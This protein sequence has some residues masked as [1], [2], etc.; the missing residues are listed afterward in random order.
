[1][2]TSIWDNLLLDTRQ[3]TFRHAKQPSASQLSTGTGNCSHPDS[4]WQLKTQISKLPFPRNSVLKTEL[5]MKFLLIAK[6]GGYV[7]FQIKDVFLLKQELS[8]SQKVMVSWLLITQSLQYSL[9]SVG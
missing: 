1:M 5:P 6:H 8:A 3:I 2:K 4:Q 7:T 9:K